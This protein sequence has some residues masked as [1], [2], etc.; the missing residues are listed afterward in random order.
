MAYLAVLGAI[1]IFIAACGGQPS[2]TVTPTSV[3]PS[4]TPEPTPTAVLT[5]TPEPTS[6]PVP[7]PTFSP[8]AVILPTV[9][10]PTRTPTPVSTDPLAATLDQIEDQMTLLREIFSFKEMERDFIT[11]SDLLVRLREDF[12]EDRAEILETQDLYVTLGILGEDSDF[13]DLLVELFGDIVSGFFDTDEEKMYIVKDT[14]DFGPGDALTYA[15][16]FTHGLQQQRFDIRAIFDAVEGNSDISRAFQ[17]LTEGDASMAQTIYMFQHMSEEDQAEARQSAPPP[18]IAFQS[19][20]HVVQR[21]IAFPY[22]EGPQFVVSL[23]VE[24]NNWDI[25][26][27]AFSEL[28]QSTEQILHP[29][30]YLDKDNREEPVSVELADVQAALGEGWIQVSRDTLGEFILL[31]Y[32]EMGVPRDQAANAAEGWGGDS[33]SLLKNAQDERLLVSKVVWD[34]EDDAQEFFDA[35]QAL[36]QTRSDEEWESVD[37]DDASRLINLA[38]QSI[39]LNIDTLDTLMIFAPDVE[40]LEAARIAADGT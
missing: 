17:A 28:P 38:N 32:L 13:F 10:V 14:P 29:E 23:L 12:E 31:A 11:K 20:P 36:M 5:P 8:G 15:H 39:F 19:A 34:S 18:S 6:T 4:A 25:V 1:L 22:V 7:T 30:K 24:S 27:Q 40:T 37:G 33:Y 16:E 2:P 26:N 9:A 3:P 21:T 35:F